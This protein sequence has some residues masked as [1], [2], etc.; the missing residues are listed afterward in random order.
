MTG[1]DKNETIVGSGKA[2]TKEFKVV[3][4]T[5]VDVRQPLQVKITQADRF[6]AAV[7]ADDNLLP[8]IH[9]VTEDGT[10][11]GTLET[12]KNYRAQTPLKLAITMPALKAVTLGGAA[13]CT[14]DGFKSPE[15]RAWVSPLF[16]K[17][18]PPAPRRLPASNLVTG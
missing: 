17:R 1:S 11:K 15:F 5:A 4:F 6:S 16:G 18:K 10:L 3:N 13:R 7:T 9:V 2:A 14:I 12:G 8:Y